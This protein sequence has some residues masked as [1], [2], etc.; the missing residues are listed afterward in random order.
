MENNNTL[1]KLLLFLL[2]MSSLYSQSQ[3]Y[4][5]TGIGAYNESFDTDNDISLSTSIA[6]FKVGYGDR[7]NYAIELILDYMPNKSKIFSSSGTY[8]GDRYGFNLALVKAFDFDIYALPFVKAGFGSGFMKIDRAMQTKLSYGS[9][10]IAAGMLLPVNKTFDIELG[11]EYRYVSYQ[12]INT[13]AQR[14]QYNAHANSVYGGI[15][16][17]F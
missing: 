17:R 8:D 6:T 15:N 4:I 1:K 12:A 7:K 16:I 13:I 11:Y 5:G 3:F 9:Y 2:L 14:V 10:N